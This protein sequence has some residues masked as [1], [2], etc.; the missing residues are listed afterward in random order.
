MLNP[1]SWARD[2]KSEFEEC[3]RILKSH[4]IL[5]FK[6]S[7]SDKKLKEILDIFPVQPLF[8]H[9]TGSRSQTHWLCFMK[10]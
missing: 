8:G 1:K 3:W 2:L 6:W 9:T 7:E 10:I 5:I 4:G